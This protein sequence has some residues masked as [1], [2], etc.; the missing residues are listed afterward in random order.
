MGG[1][2]ALPLSILLWRRPSSRATDRGALQGVGP[3]YEVAPR[4]AEGRCTLDSTL[5]L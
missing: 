5:V 4:F 3:Q 1:T 2:A